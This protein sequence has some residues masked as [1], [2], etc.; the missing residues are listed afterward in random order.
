VCC[1]VQLEGVAIDEMPR[2]YLATP[3]EI[4]QCLRETEPGLG[5]LMLL[6]AAEPGSGAQEQAGRNTIPASWKFSLKRIEEM[7][8]SQEPASLLKLPP[9][10][11][12]PQGRVLPFPD[13]LGRPRQ[14]ALALGAG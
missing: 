4:A 5:G 9:V 1:L 14:P 7:A 6:E 8:A 10:A 3:R 2:L 11:E 12:N 13:Q